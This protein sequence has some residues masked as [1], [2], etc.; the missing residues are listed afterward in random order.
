MINQQAKGGKMVKENDLGEILAQELERIKECGGRINLAEIERRTG[1][2]LTGQSS[3]QTWMRLSA[4]STGFATTQSASHSQVIATG[5]EAGQ[6]FHW[7][8]RTQS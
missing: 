4:H 5:A 6:L 8:S 1:M 7:T 2:S 3:S